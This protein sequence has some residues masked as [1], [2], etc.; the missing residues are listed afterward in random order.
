MGDD[1]PLEVLAGRRIGVDQMTVPAGD[2]AHI[3]RFVVLLGVLLYDDG[4]RRMVRL[5]RR[6]EIEAEL[7]VHDVQHRNVLAGEIVEHEA[8]MVRLVEQIRQVPHRGSQRFDVDDER[9]V[10][11]PVGGDQVELE[12]VAVDGAEPVDRALVRT[13]GGHPGRHIEDGDRAGCHGASLFRNR[14]AACTPL[15]A[16]QPAN[17]VAR[18]DTSAARRTQPPRPP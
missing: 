13:P 17:P 11:R 10:H 1:A 8:G 2:V 15:A 9:V 18:W 3:Q 7:A 4:H 5:H 12:T 14:R 16:A 6:D